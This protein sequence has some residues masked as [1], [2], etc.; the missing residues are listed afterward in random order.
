MAGTFMLGETKVRPGSYFNIQKKGGNAAVSVMNGVTAVIF[1]ADFG[2]LN[3]AVEISADDKYEEIFGNGLTTDAIKEAFAGGAKTVIG[4]RV[5]SGGTQ[6]TVELKDTNETP[7]TAVT[8]TAKYPGAKAFTATIRTKLSDSNFKE[9]VIYAG[10]TEFE[11]VEFAAGAGEALALKTA[12]DASKNFTAAVAS[13]KDQ[14][15][16]ALVSQSAFTAGTNPTTANSDYSNAFSQVEPYEFNTICVDT[17][18]SSIHLL[19]QSFVSRIFDAG[20]LVQA[21]VAEIQTVALDTRMAHAAAFNDEKMNYVLNAKISEQGT[22]IDGYKTAARIAGMI[23]ACSS[24]SSLTHTVIN[25]FTELLEN[26]TNTQIINA[27]KKGCIVLSYNKEK[28]VWID[29]AINTLITPADNQDDGWKKI[30]RVK[31]RFELMRRVNDT[32]DKLVGKV[33]N[34]A[35][36]RKTVISQV[37]GVGDAMKEEGKLIACAVT[38]ST[39]YKADGDSAW[40]DIDVV[41]KDSMEHIYLR[42]LFRFSTNE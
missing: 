3:K 18:D 35:N 26:L 15:I 14:A 36:G 9:C 6:G 23:G 37:Q 25:G 20:S 4:C 21:V 10:T 31:T 5:G 38:E 19:L 11:K 41:D 42:F 30:R 17:E 32:T 22:T 29:S 8:I 2:P 34:D 13:G 28:Q 1:K 33:D 39:V 7:A 12:L 24:A 27:E 16:L 40:F